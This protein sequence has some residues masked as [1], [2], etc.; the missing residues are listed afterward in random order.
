[1][2]DFETIDTADVTEEADC[3]EMEPMNEL[4]VGNDVQLRS[5]VKSADPEEPT[6]W[7][8]QDANGGIWK[9]DLSFSFTSQAPE[10]LMSFHAGPITGCDTCPVSHLVATTGIDSKYH[11]GEPAGMH[12]R[13]ITDT[14]SLIRL[15]EMYVM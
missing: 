15:L 6:M 1:M 4:K 14:G 10:K 11:R 5:I 7:Y 8:A 9:L 3:F 2:W 13:Y 12:S